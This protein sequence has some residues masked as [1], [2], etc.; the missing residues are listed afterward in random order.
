[1]KKERELMQRRFYRRVFV[2]RLSG[3]VS[4][5]RFFINKK[6]NTGW[7]EFARMKVVPE[8]VVVDKTNQ[9]VAAVVKYEGKVYL[10]VTVDFVR[11]TVK[12]EGSLKKI[13]K[14]IQPFTK[15]RY[16][17]MIEEEARFLVND[18]EA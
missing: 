9:L 7:T 6:S 1:M 10:T 3:M 18:H 8:Y 17:D 15:Q 11:N 2:S 12:A 14:V 5:C 16:I 13:E 4:R